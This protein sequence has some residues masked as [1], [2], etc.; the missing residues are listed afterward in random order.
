MAI[1]F[2]MTDVSCDRK[3]RSVAFDMPLPTIAISTKGPTD[4][5]LTPVMKTI[6]LLLAAAALSF[7]TSCLPLAVGATAGYVA[8][9]DGYRVR[10]PVT[11]D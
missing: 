4:L 10:N 9:E 11:H 7:L 5:T 6:T 3:W 2:A 8:H 1:T